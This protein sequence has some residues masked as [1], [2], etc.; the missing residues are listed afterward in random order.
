MPLVPV[1]P[2]VLRDALALLRADA[3]DDAEGS[4]I[5]AENLADPAA[6]ARALA[7]VLRVHMDAYGDRVLLMDAWQRGAGL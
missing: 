6:T 7:H 2:D 4:Q 5:V 3:A 1:S